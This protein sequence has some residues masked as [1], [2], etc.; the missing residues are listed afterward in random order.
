MAKAITLL[1]KL[2]VA[3]KGFKI[4]SAIAPGVKTFAGAIVSMTGKGIATLAGKLFGVA[5]GEK[6][7]GTASKE[8]S[9]T[10]VE[11]AKAFVAIGAGVALIAAGFS[12]LAYSAVQ[13]HKLDHW[14]Q[15][16]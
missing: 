4:V 16:Y 7:V 10:I 3:F 2:Y 11:S 6:A 14:Q 9:G 1:P 8:S 13:S 15:E 12:L 5:A